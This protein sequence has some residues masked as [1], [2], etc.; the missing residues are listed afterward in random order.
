MR[1]SCVDDRSVEFCTLQVLFADQTDQFASLKYR[2]IL[3]PTRL[4]LLQGIARV[5]V[6]G[7]GVRVTHHPLLNGRG[8]ILEN[9]MSHRLRLVPPNY[10]T[11]T[12]PSVIPMI[13][14]PTA[15]VPNAASCI[16]S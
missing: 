10:E 7:C 6:P 12:A 13:G 9:M 15:W 14:R 1:S 5:F 4:H 11:V 3:H 2:R 16:M 8:V